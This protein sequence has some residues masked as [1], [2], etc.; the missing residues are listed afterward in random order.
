M[1][2]NFELIEKGAGSRILLVTRFNRLCLLWNKLGKKC[3]RRKW[4]LC[5]AMLSG[6]KNVLTSAWHFPIFRHIFP[7]FGISTNRQRGHDSL[8]SF[9]PER[10]AWVSVC[11]LPTTVVQLYIHTYI[12]YFFISIP[13]WDWTD[14]SEKSFRTQ[15]FESETLNS[16]KCFEW[17]LGNACTNIYECRHDDQ[18]LSVCAVVFEWN[19]WVKF[20]T[21]KKRE[22]PSPVV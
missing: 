6:M 15:V 1:C 20:G 19:L 9:K 8:P 21:S 11:V 5:S 17:S 10:L 7:R 16:F 22:I 3:I 18:V 14:C 13:L 12:R 4:R 2:V